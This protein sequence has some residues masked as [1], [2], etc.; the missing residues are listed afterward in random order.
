[1]APRARPGVT[2]F[3]LP[4]AMMVASGAI[5]AVVNAIVKGPKAQASDPLHARMVARGSTD[6]ASALLLLPATL[7]VAWPSGAIGWLAISAAVHL[8]YLYAMIRTYAVADLSAAYPVMR[9]SAP[10]LTAAISV[11][12]FG[13]RVAIADLAGI[14]M[15][16]AAILTLVL[17]RHLDA[18]A[19]GW[20]LTTGAMTALY[21]VADAHGVRAAPS[22]AS[23][24]AWDFVLIGAISIAMFAGLTRG[25]LFA[26]LRAQWRPG[27]A[28]GTLSVVTY[29]L[30]L[31]ALSL[32]PTAPLAALRETG[33]VTALILSV[34]FLGESVTWRRAA[35][36]GGI[37]AGAGLILLG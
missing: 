37:L 26:D 15:I 18:K 32:G 16:G 35:A 13:E 27:A 7:L 9:G 33:M 14:A 21:T 22:P 28:A 34:A 3:I 29:G 19:L 5:H 24:I 20:A 36:V 30:A 6:G 23:Y 17:G 25:R 2:P 1:M 8:V 4:A 11:G 31:W 10:L 12:L